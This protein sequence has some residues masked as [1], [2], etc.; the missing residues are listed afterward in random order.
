MIRTLLVIATAA[1]LAFASAQA[2]G[3]TTIQLIL[4]ASGSMFKQLADGRY[5]ITAAKDALA[6]V[7]G[8]L[9]DQNGLQVGLR[10][11]GS[12]VDALAEGACQD[13]HLV[14]PMTG[15]ERTALLSAV[16]D[17]QARGATPIA[18]S[19][20]LALQ[21]FA[22][23]TGDK[24][25]ILVTD[26]AES[27]G[28]DVRA[29]AEQLAAA[30]IDLRVIGF[31][32]D[33][34]A[35]ASFAGIGA[36]ENAQSAQELARALQQAVAPTSPATAAAFP[37]TVRVVRDG[38]PAE[39][40]SVTFVS[41]VSE[42]P[43]TLTSTVPG[44]L[45]G[46]IPPGQY[47]AMVADALADTPQPVA[48]V[49]VTP[50][51]DNAFTFEL[52]KAAQVEV[53]V[54]PAEPTAGSRVAVSF[55]GAPVQVDPWVAIAPAGAPDDV[56]LTWTYAG[57]ATGTVEIGTPPE[58]ATLEAR[59]QVDLP[60]G[61]TRVLG[62]S[63]PFTTVAV[64][65]TLDAA[66]E[67]VAG[68]QV[69]VGWTGPD[70]DGDYIT[71]VPVGAPQGSFGSWAYTESG[72]PVSVT[73]PLQAGAYEARYVAGQGDAPTLASVPI[74]IVGADV[75][76][77][78]PE[79]VPARTTFEVAWSGPGNDGDYIT[80]VPVGAAQG[81][82]LSYAYTYEGNPVSLEA[83]EA[84]GRYEVRYTTE[85]GDSPTLASQPIEVMGVDYTL[86]APATVAPGEAF[87]VAWT[88]PAAAGDY[89]TIVP[90]GAPEGDYLD[91]QYT[92]MG[93]P[94]IL[95]APD[96]PGEYEVRYQSD[97]APGVFA[98][99]PITVE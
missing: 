41:A 24:L 5:R 9:P 66:G 76:L 32:L 36:F 79:R 98:S 29:M 68:A 71:I 18:H 30:G 42:E 40:A 34:R 99:T 47:R 72:N 57:A 75:A 22:G 90:A 60:E 31:D 96:E 82:Y 3:T 65:A 37:V 45:T 12:Q 87:E 84:P 19:L 85:Q 64:K 80:I 77:S 63:E 46:T 59:V 74:E 28:G 58:P 83:P 94:L 81:T 27:C 70:N 50:D 44:T 13:S 62:R 52:A 6:D 7:I 23:A 56:Y 51:G 91:Y 86:N 49:T 11:Y 10:V 73:A 53:T 78:A 14:V 92:D 55:A 69:A 33:E 95:T 93:S 26:G 16:R 35:A 8:G 48:T 43:F 4:D 1:A 61:G 25:L 88:G 89:I 21:D 17:T 15:F 39:G 20:E 97:N 38:V 54:A 2:A 67:A